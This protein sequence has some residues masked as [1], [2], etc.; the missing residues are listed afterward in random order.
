M[1]VYS[2]LLTVCMTFY[3]KMYEEHLEVVGCVVVMLVLMLLAERDIQN[4]LQV[5]RSDAEVVSAVS[6]IMDRY[7]HVGKDYCYQAGDTT[8]VAMAL[9]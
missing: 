9:Q 8:A 7:G 3:T 6:G 1:F 5:C 2:P 4:I